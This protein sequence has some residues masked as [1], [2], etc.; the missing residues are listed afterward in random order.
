[1]VLFPANDMPFEL[2]SPVGDK[3]VEGAPPG[4]SCVISSPADRYIAIARLESRL[5]KLVSAVEAL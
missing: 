2:P 5:D 1:M 3:L 4:V